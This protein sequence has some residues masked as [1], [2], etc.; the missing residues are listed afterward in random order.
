LTK[1]LTDKKVTA[2]VNA[3]LTKAGLSVTASAPAVAAV[4]K[5]V[6]VA[7]KTN[8]TAVPTHA[9]VTMSGTLSGAG[10]MWCMMEKAGTA[11]AKKTGRLLAANGTNATNGTTKAAAPAV[12]AYAALRK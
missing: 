5:E 6:T 10:Y 4:A 12:D 1:S 3:G 2:A 11:P 8:P 7:M 9:N